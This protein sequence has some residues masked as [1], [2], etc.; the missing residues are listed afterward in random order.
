MKHYC[1]YVLDNYS[2]RI[3]PEVKGALLKRGYV[4]T[5]IGGGITGDIQ[6]NDTDIHAHLKRA[7]QQLEQE[8]MIKQL[9]SDQKKIPQPS[10]NDMMRMLVESLQIIDVDVQG[11]YK[12]L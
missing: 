8:L 9:Q 7:Y 10:C 3:I 11:R 6:I 4:Y 1:I 2:V 5:G 12:S